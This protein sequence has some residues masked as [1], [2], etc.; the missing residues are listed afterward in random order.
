MAND[1]EESPSLTGMEEFNERFKPQNPNTRAE[2]KTPTQEQIRDGIRATKIHG[3]IG[4]ELDML[5]RGS[6][7]KIEV[8]EALANAQLKLL[9]RFDK[10]KSQLDRLKDMAYLD[11]LTGLLNRRSYDEYMQANS[12]KK[13]GILFIDV[14]NFKQVNNFGYEVGDEALK[15]VSNAMLDS[16]G[17]NPI[18]FRV[19]GDEFVAVY[20]ETDDPTTLKINAEETRENVGSTELETTTGEVVPFSVSVSGGI[21]AGG[22]LED[23]DAYKNM[24]SSALLANKQQG[25]KNV[26]YIFGVDDMKT[27]GDTPP[28]VQVSDA[29]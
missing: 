20:E 5:A 9:K 10:M 4:V 15:I 14:D 24:V 16:R 1:N 23:V 13:K 7:S 12:G 21:F 6:K 29:A 25:I 28:S 19:G 11:P 22:S 27:G 17:G 26:S 8:K 3:D 18:L 2:Q